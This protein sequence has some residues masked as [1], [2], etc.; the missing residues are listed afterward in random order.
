MA[1][2]PCALVELADVPGELQEEWRRWYDTVYLPARVAVPGVRSGRRGAGV[3]DRAPRPA[4]DAALLDIG[5]F[6]L[7]DEAVLHSLEW[8]ES[9]R[10]IA[11]ADG[12]WRDR[13]RAF[14][15]STVYRSLGS[16]ERDYRP[17]EAAILHGAFFEV[18][19]EHHDE[20]NDWYDLEHIP[21]IMD[22]PGYLNARRFQSAE[23]P[24]KF[25]ALYD[26][27]SLA[28]A[29]GPVAERATQSPWSDRVRA[30]LVRK[31]ALR[32]FTV[33]ALEFGGREVE[34]LAN[35]KTEG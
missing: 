30:K 27:D 4:M 34:I 9:E 10:R 17:G 2:T 12:S 26:V 32:L 25:A 18:A 1:M 31:R 28:T 8:T 7:E 21:A 14:T 5:V 13:R 24:D 22:V 16:P 33:E 29:R 6:D 23:D 3:D 11:D 20:F 19:P 15:T 35:P